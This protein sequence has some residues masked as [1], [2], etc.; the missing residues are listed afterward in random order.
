MTATLPR[1][2]Y[3]EAG[4][5]VALL[6]LNH[7]VHKATINPEDDARGLVEHS[8]EPVGLTVGEAVPLM[9]QLLI[10]QAGAAAESRLTGADVAL[11][12]EEGDEALQL[13]GT[14]H[15]TW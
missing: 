11:L 15:A 5:V 8:A 12:G 13:A 9:H 14:I 4:H 6:L 3:H 2:A 1:A 10:V 7:Q